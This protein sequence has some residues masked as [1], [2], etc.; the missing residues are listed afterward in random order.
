MTGRDRGEARVNKND[1]F[2]ACAKPR[3]MVML[4]A[5]TG[6]S[7]CREKSRRERKAGGFC[8]EHAEPKEYMGHPGGDV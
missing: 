6:N 8:F 3:R 1:R 4:S 7:K 2:Q 5:Q